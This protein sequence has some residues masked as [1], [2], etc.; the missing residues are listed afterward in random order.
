M[1]ERAEEP[2][3]RSDGRLDPEDM[4]ALRERVDHL[5]AQHADR[6]T[7]AATAVEAS[8][9]MRLAGRM[10]RGGGF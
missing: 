4:A 8:R 1:A 9:R 7:R 3:N 10:R 5:R 2:R 6:M